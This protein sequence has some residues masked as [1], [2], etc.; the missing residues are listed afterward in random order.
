MKLLTWNVRGLGNKR[1][2]RNIKEIVCKE[3]LDVV[4]FQ[5]IKR[6]IINWALI[7]V[8]WGIRYKD[9]AFL[10]SEGRSGGILI[11]WDV[12]TITAKECISGNFTL[13]LRFASKSREKWW[14]TG[15]LWPHVS[16]GPVMNFGKNWRAFTDF[17]G[18]NG[19]LE[20]TLM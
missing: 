19:V 5:E 17:V 16:I 15:G 6:E 11:I 1:K 13:S 20:G 12:R 4:I 9:W 8:V 7:G 18:I 10:P 3:K 14:V 2:R